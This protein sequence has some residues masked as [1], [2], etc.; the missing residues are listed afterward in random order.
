AEAQ[1]EREHRA[2]QTALGSRVSDALKALEEESVKTTRLTLALTV[3][4]FLQA[5][6]F[7]W[8]LMELQKASRIANSSA[9]AARRAVLMARDN[10]RRELRA[11]LGVGDGEVF[12]LP[13]AAH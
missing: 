2:N 6:F 9:Q 1:E 8:Q 4:A 5:V 13:T 7:V 12:P 11:Y 10:S 3:I